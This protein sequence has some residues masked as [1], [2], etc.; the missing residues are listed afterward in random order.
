MALAPLDARYEAPLDPRCAEIMANVREKMSQLSAAVTHTTTRLVG[1]TRRLQL[2]RM[3]SNTPTVD[4]DKIVNVVVHQAEGVKRLG[5][6]TRR[7]TEQVKAA[8]P[9]RLTLDGGNRERSP[10]VPNHAAAGSALPRAR[11]VF[12][13][14]LSAPAM[15]LQTSTR[16]RAVPRTPAGD[17]AGST[18][19]LPPSSG[20]SHSDG[21]TAAA[22]ATPVAV[23]P[24]KQRQHEAA[25]RAAVSDKLMK[26]LWPGGVATATGKAVWGRQGSARSLRA[27][28]QPKPS[29]EQHSRPRSLSVAPPATATFSRFA[30]ISVAPTP[31]ITV[32]GGLAATQQRQRTQP[33]VPSTPRLP[34][35]MP[36][37]SRSKS[38]AA[39]SKTGKL[40]LEMARREKA[41][42]DRRQAMAAAR[43]EAEARAKEEA[44]KPPPVVTTTGAGAG[45]GAGAGVGVGAGAG[46]GAGVGAGVGAGAGAGVGVGAGAVATPN[47][48]AAS[49]RTIQGSQPKGGTAPVAAT[50]VPVSL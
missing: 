11:P 12:R 9:G 49:S 27:A 47:A 50:A 24:S 31:T 10:S 40:L 32:P 30:S 2:A 44:K 3:P 45:A 20:R 26:L 36:G 15:K 33:A 38:S 35:S 17:N 37:L 7:L 25:T 8:M 48:T 5:D 13:R 14:A 43:A 6:R 1:V 18:A 23:S 28:A 46:A 34:R 29:S 16:K 4:I 19:P 21:H 41:M 42:K 22:P 39:E